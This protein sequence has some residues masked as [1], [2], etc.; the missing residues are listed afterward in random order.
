MGIISLVAYAFYLFAP[1][2]EIHLKDQKDK[3]LAEQIATLNGI[4][5]EKLKL[6]KVASKQ[7]ELGQ[8]KASDYNH[9]SSPPSKPRFTPDQNSNKLK[10]PSKP[11]FEDEESAS[12]KGVENKEMA[13]KIP[14]AYENIK[15]Q[16]FAK[17][18]S[19]KEDNITDNSSE[20]LK[21]EST[22]TALENEQI[23]E[24]NSFLVS[25]KPEQKVNGEEIQETPPANKEV[26]ATDQEKD[27]KSDDTSENL[28]VEDEENLNEE[29]D[30]KPSGLLSNI[31]NL[32]TDNMIVNALPKLNKWPKVAK[33]MKKP[34]YSFYT[35][36]MHNLNTGE[37]LATVFYQN[38]EYSQEGLNKI[39]KF[40][41]DYRT[42]EVTKIDPKL[43]ML[44]YR[45]TR[46]LKFDGYIEVISGYRS[47]KTNN[48]LR[49]QGRNVAKKSMH[50]EGK[51]ID[52]K[53][54]GVSTKRL[55][56][57]AQ[58]FRSGGVGYYPNDGFV[59]VD[60]GDLRS[61]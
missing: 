44:V 56:N 4:E 46:R 14:K 19:N 24:K 3:S 34:Q 6:E 21:S 52:I 60:T 25:F 45:I 48:K 39:N 1:V 53:L 11:A 9:K 27:K 2:V 8:E 17:P 42:G 15:P 38:G 58:A 59:H 5:S 61:W 20:L 40:L 26:P 18:K 36:R 55:R 37:H 23:K 28:V 41:R 47:K 16:F 10:I 35:L 57:I 12:V 7:D 32:V 31:K 43:M 33:Y 30:E 50:S 51:A 13:I 54:P 49:R 22:K 29:P